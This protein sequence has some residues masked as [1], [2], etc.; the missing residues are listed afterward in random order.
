MSSI[1]HIIRRRRARRQNRQP[2]VALWGGMGVAAALVLLVLLIGAGSVVYAAAAY[3]GAAGR[4]PAQPAALAATSPAGQ[5]TMLLDRAAQRVIYRLQPM[6]TGAAAWVDLDELPPVV[7]QATVAIE[8]GIFFSRGGFNLAILAESLNAAVLNG[9]QAIDDPILLY[10]ARNAVVP[11][12]EMPADSPDRVFTDAV[13]MLELRRR[14]SREELLAWFLNTALYGNGAYGIEAAAQAYFGKHAADLTLAEAAALAGIPDAPSINPFD[15]PAEAFRRQNLVLDAMLGY[16][17][18]DAAEIEAARVQLSVTHP[19]A[20]ADVVAPHYGL[21][22]RR[23]AESLLNEAGYDGARLVAAGGLRITTSLDLDL[24]YQAECVLRTHLTRLGG[25]DPTFVYATS[26]GQPCVAAGYLPALAAEDVG[27]SHGVTNGAVVITSPTTGEVLAYVGSMDYWN[28]GIRGYVDSAEARYEPG[29][30]IRPYIYLT[31]LARGF[32]AATMTLDVQRQFEQPFG[33]TLLVTSQDGVYRGPI[34]LRQAAVVD[35]AA[36]AVEV[37]NWVGVGDVVGTAHRM[38]L[39][40]LSDSPTSY[41]LSL[42]LEGGDV[43]LLDLAYSFGVLANQG[44]MVG[45]P[46]SHAQERAGFRALDPVLVL[47]IED[48]Q[49]VLLWEYQPQTRDTLAPVLAYLMNDILGDREMRAQLYGVD[50]VYEIGRP[51]A[52]YGGTPLQG[53]SAWTVGYTPQISAGVWLGNVDQTPTIGLDA[54]NGPAAIWRAVMRYV[55]ERDG[56]PAQDWQAPASVVEVAVCAVSGLLPNAYCPVVREMFAQGTQPTQTDFYY[57]MVEVN[58]QN[59]LRAT[60]STP[61]DL[62]EQRV[63][64]SYPAEAQAWASA[65][66]RSGPPDQYDTVGAPVVLG[67]VAILAP[68]PFD[69]VRGVVDVRGNATLPGFQ[70]YQLAYGQGLNPPNWLQIGAPV[71]NP[72]RGALLG[73]WDTTGLE[74]LYSLRLTVV[75]ADQTVQESVIQL[76]VDN[77]PPQIRVSSPIEGEELR[78]SGSNPVLD[79]AVEY[80]DNVGVAEVMYYLDGEA[81]GSAIEPPFAAPI[82]LESLGQHS[83]W[84][85]AFDAAGNSALSE[86]VNFSVRRGS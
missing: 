62:V 14:F 72:A 66:G 20:P 56:L 31:A 63:Y 59:G 64:F 51:A 18:V 15:Q 35:A 42:A 8:D 65:N 71:S 27:V 77:T 23:Q 61:R 30:L 46:V 74:G 84:A 83:L 44:R 49:G 11:L 32:T 34:S 48:A 29:S 36:P 28:T 53:R 7:W 9:R 69:Y 68:E 21:A 2:G 60:A 40:S 73:R 80:S 58:R 4:I 19:L 6:T 78:I 38:G 12:Y 22:A 13:I 81:V 85:E 75:A 54:A 39:N 26:V 5:P 3:L 10:L 43:R 76:T 82:M 50:N 33:S 45:A 57:Q 79:V 52:V 86:R 47:R 37:M 24:Q 55:H 17:M 67:P 25:V 1:P 70:S 41:D 16:G